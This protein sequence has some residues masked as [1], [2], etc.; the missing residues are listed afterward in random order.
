MGKS[1]APA[2]INPY[3]SAEAQYQY[4]TQAGNYQTALN[5]VN[6]VGPTGTTSY[7]VTG[8]DAS[9]AP[10]RTQ[11]TTLSPQQQAL[12]GGQQTLQQG[13]LGQGQTLLNQFSALNAQGQPNIAPVQYSVGAQPVNGNIDSSGVPGIVNTQDAY[14]SGQSTA[15][16]GIMAGLNPS[17]DN[18]REQLDSSLRNSGAHPGDEAYDRAMSALDADQAGQ[19][20]QGAGAAV[21]AGN[22]LQNTQYGESAN[23][24]SQLFSQAAAKQQAGAGAASTNFQQA[25]SN[26]GL[27]NSAGTTALANYAN[28]LGIPINELSAILG[29]TQVSTPSAISPGSASISAPNIQDAFNQSYQQGLAKSNSD[30]ANF[31]STVGDA[32]ALS[33]LG[34]LAFA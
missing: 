5:D 1:S 21:S 19:R 15:L 30:T 26:A 10:I 33:Y 27:N 9:G 8:M 31:N 34:Y 17:L 6:T 4:G 12:L 25:L 22:T 24:N 2:P 14:T 23:T 7:A 3:Q 28:E 16:A 20:A 18:Q 13:E 29:G 11:T 32:A